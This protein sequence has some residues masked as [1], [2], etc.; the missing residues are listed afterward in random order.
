MKFSKAFLLTMVCVFMLSACRAM[1]PKNS[2]SNARHAKENYLA[3]HSSF[4]NWHAI[5]SSNNLCIEH[6]NFIGGNKVDTYKCYSAD[7][8]KIVDT[9]RFLNINRA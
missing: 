2:Q 3:R 8:Q 9:Y 5:V 4:I 1:L 6:F 7:Y